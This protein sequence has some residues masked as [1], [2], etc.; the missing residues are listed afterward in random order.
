MQGQLHETGD[1]HTQQGDKDKGEYEP[2]E[3]K[4]L[5]AP[6]VRGTCRHASQRTQQM[7]Y[8]IAVDDGWCSSDSLKMQSHTSLWLQCHC[9]ACSALHCTQCA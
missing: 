8:G 4:Y 2:V 5:A 7:T 1:E 6:W 3:A 9:S